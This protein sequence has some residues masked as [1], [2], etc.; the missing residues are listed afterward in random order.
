MAMISSLISKLC[1]NKR[2]SSKCDGDVC[3]RDGDCGRLS[4]CP[5]LPSSL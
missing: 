3:W 5:A 4:H 1:R 2:I